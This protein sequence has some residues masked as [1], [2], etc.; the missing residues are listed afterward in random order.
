MSVLKAI[1]KLDRNKIFSH[2]LYTHTHI[3]YGEGEWCSLC[4]ICFFNTNKALSHLPTVVAMYIHVE[5][6][7]GSVTLPDTVNPI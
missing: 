3:I 2:I 7:M 1:Q 6:T 4:K 5:G